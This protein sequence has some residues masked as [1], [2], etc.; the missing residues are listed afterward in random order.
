MK[1]RGRYFLLLGLVISSGSAGGQRVGPFDPLTG[2]ARSVIAGTA[3]GRERATTWVSPDLFAHIRDVRV[4]A[5]YFP[6]GIDTDSAGGR[7]PHGLIG[8][9]LGAVAGGVL[10]YSWVRAYCETSSGCN[11]ARPILTGAAIGAIV[12]A[13]LEYF[14]RHGQR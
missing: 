6:S 5:S 14:I 9:A 1:S 13:V 8:G 11:S 7:V 10:G 12:G 4:G 2:S 3:M